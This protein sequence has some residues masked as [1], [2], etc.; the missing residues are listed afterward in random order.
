MKKLL[1]IAGVLISLSLHAQPFSEEQETTV[2]QIAM[3]KSSH[4]QMAY[5]VGFSS[6]WLNNL[7]IYLQQN[8]YSYFEQPSNDNLW[9]AK[10]KPRTG[11]RNAYLKVAGNIDSKNIISTVTVTGTPDEVVRLFLYYWDNDISLAQLKKGGYIYQDHGTDRVTFDWKGTDPV[12]R[13]VKNP[14]APLITVSQK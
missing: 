6:Q 2:Q 14:D 12:V 3:R 8:G 11:S 5:F 4:G 9:A 7:S 10:F 1:T 13:I